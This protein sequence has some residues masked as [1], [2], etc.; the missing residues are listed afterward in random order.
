MQSAH[1]ELITVSRQF[2][3]GGSELARKIG[4]RLNWKPSAR[5][6]DGLAQT[7]AWVAAQIEGSISSSHRSTP[8]SAS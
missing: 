8:A 2:G 5:L 1:I 6:R 3:A 7:Y 4:E